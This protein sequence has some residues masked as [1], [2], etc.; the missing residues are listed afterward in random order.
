MPGPAQ[1]QADG[2]LQQIHRPARALIGWMVEEQAVRLLAGQRRDIPASEEMLSRVRSARKAAAAR[3]GD[4]DQTDVIRDVPT[5][6]EQHVG[7]LRESQAAKAYFDEGWRVA[8]AD[9]RKV[10]ALQPS[11]FTDHAEERTAS[12][13][14]NDLESLVAVSLPLPTQ[15][16]IPAQF[17]EHR[18]AW[19]IS[20]P[21][22]NLRIVGNWAGQVQGGLMGFGFAVALLQSFVQVAHVQDRY[23]L[24]DGYHRALGLLKRGVSFVPVLVRDYA[25]YE[26]LGVAPGL[27][28]QSVYLGN[29]PPRLVDYFDDKVSAEVSLPA[30]QKMIVIHGLELTPMG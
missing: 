27:L 1:T 15:V 20:S 11:I 24:R 12:V 25:Q 16:A 8:L 3:T 18:Q 14:P 30:F 2:S 6:L 17:D 7:K 28:P 9:L 5:A 22:P 19:I 10:C 23:V 29:R 21:N 26:D 13:D 4:A